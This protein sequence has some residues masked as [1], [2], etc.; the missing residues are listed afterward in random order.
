MPRRGRLGPTTQASAFAAGRSRHGC[1]DRLLGGWRGDATETSGGR[2]EDVSGHL[3]RR[4]KVQG[5]VMENRLNR[6][7]A[8]AQANCVVRLPGAHKFVIGGRN[9]STRYVA[10]APPTAHERFEGLPATVGHLAPP[11]APRLGQQVRVVGPRR[12]I[13]QAARQGPSTLRP[14][15][16]AGRRPRRPIV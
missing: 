11:P 5:V 2:L 12:Q 13:K 3:R 15:Q 1:S 10:L 14:G 8:S 9:V 6:A 4:H 7:Q 16:P